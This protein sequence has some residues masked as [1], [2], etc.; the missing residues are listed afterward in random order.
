MNIDQKD[1]KNEEKQAKKQ[2]EEL[3]QKLHL[4]NHHYFDLDIPI[5]DDLVYD[6]ELNKL[7]N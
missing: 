4:W 6:Q 1:Y 5:V 2:I 3:R 7:K